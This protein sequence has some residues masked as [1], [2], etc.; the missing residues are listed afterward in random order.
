MIPS[1]RKNNVSSNNTPESAIE[2]HLRM[3]K[4]SWNIWNNYKIK[5]ILT[6]K[7]RK[8]LKNKKEKKLKIKRKSKDSTIQMKQKK[9]LKL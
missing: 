3:I 4:N 1:R 5:L 6:L 9:P 7:K 8:E 2:K